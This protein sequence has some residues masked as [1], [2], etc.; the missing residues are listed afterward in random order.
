[1]SNAGYLL[2]KPSIIAFKEGKTSFEADI[3][4]YTIDGRHLYLLGKS[5]IATGSEETWDKVYYA[6]AGSI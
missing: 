4:K 6:A 2:L 5:L 1:M 3:I